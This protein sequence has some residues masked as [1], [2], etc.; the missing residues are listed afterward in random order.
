MLE[1]GYP[2]VHSEY[3]TV[4]ERCIVVKILVKLFRISKYGYM[5]CCLP[6]IKWLSET[7]MRTAQLMKTVPFYVLNQLIT[8]FVL[9]SVYHTNLINVWT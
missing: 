8:K 5:I 3:K 9:C 1:R 7:K 6:S 4:S 2:P